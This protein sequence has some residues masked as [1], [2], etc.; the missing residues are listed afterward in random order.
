MFGDPDP[1][2]LADLARVGTR[3]SIL[4]EQSL[5][6]IWVYRYGRRISSRKDGIQ[7]RL[8]LK[9]YWLLF[10]IVE[11]VT[12]ISLP[13]GSSIGAGLRIWHFGG[14]F[15]HP[16]AVIG[17]NCTIRHGVTIGNRGSDELAPV[18][19]NSVE[20][21]AYAQILGDVRIGDGC[22]IGALTVVVK[23]LPSGCVAVGPP[24]RILSPRTGEDYGDH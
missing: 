7:K 3:R 18:L 14:V 15:V 16:N 4:R 2:W 19:G 21:G 20:L 6:A 12:G 1:D 23:N 8:L 9:W 13:I 11:T 24:A 5:W 22:R 17:R 10:S